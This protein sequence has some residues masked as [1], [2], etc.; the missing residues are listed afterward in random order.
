MKPTFLTVKAHF[1]AGAEFFV[2]SGDDLT[3]NLKRSPNLNN[4]CLAC[5]VINGS[6]SQRI[7]L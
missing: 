5:C 7:Y 2:S 1:A 6:S 4:P 3:G